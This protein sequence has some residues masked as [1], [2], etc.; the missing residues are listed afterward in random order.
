MA[1]NGIKLTASN[2]PASGAAAGPDNVGLG[3]VGIIGLGL[4]GGSLARVLQ[5]KAGV[6]VI[7]F[8]RKP[9][10]IQAALADGALTSGAVLPNLPEV[11]GKPGT[12]IDPDS[13]GF[14]QPSADDESAWQQLA[15]CEVVFVCT[16]P[17][18]VPA[19]VKMAARYCGGILT[20]VASVKRPIMEKI[21]IGRFIGGHPMAGSERAG[22]A[23]SSEN[24]L[25]H[26]VYIICLPAGYPGQ[27]DGQ[28]GAVEL[29]VGQ[30]AR[31]DRLIRLTGAAP[32]YLDAAEHDRAVA[33]VS[34]LPHVAAAGLSL[35][36]ALSDRGPLARLAAGGFRDITRIASSDATLWSGIS[37][38][39]AQ[40]LLPAIDRYIQL[41]GDFRDSLGNRDSQAL[42]G[43]FAQAA[44]YRDSLPAVERTP[45]GAD[46]AE[47]PGQTESARP[48]DRQGGLT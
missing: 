22:Y 25:E 33:V 32:V 1:E 39:N 24:L 48:Q 28:P 6:P 20:D 7:G 47:Q 27:G 15:G 13:P 18:T 31:F 21:N 34:H 23:H 36:A 8:D 10:V 12:L 42:Q 45:A 16:P 41:L 40:E 43:Y 37:L 14:P 26:A 9:A 19:Y 2:Q 29:S 5:R 3:P 46:Q 11:P 4:I 44:R 38:E 35:L 17:A 30:V